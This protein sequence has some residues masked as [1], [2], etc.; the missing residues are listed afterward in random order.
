MGKTGRLIKEKEWP[1]QADWYSILFSVTGMGFILERAGECAPALTQDPRT[2]NVKE[3]YVISPTGTVRYFPGNTVQLDE[4]PGNEPRLDLL[5]LKENVD[6]PGKMELV[7]RKGTPA[8]R[9]K[10]PQLPDPDSEIQIPIAVVGFQEY[11]DQIHGLFDARSVLDSEHHHGAGDALQLDD[12]AGEMSVKTDGTTVVMQNGQLHLDNTQIVTGD[13]DIEWGNGLELS[14][15]GIRVKQ[16]YGLRFDHV[17]SVAVEDQELWLDAAAVSG[18]GLTE[19]SSGKIKVDTGD[20]VAAGSS[21][22]SMDVGNGLALVS[23]QLEADLVSGGGLKLDADGKLYVDANDFVNGVGLTVSSG[24][25][26]LTPGTGLRIDTD[27]R[28]DETNGLRVWSEQLEVYAGTGVEFNADGK[29]RLNYADLLSALAGNGILVNNSVLEVGAS[30]GLTMDHGQLTGD[31]GAGITLGSYGL[32]LDPDETT[33]TLSNGAL[34]VL[35]SGIAGD[36]LTNE[37]PNYT[38]EMASSTGGSVDPPEGTHEYT[39]GAEVELNAYPDQD[40]DFSS[41]GGDI[42][43]YDNPETI[44]INSDLYVKG[45]FEPSGIKSSGENDLTAT[46]GGTD[47]LQVALGE[48]VG[49]DSGVLKVKEGTGVSIGSGNPV[50]INRSEI[51]GST[52][53]TYTDGDGVVRGETNF[54]QHAFEKVDYSNSAVIDA[55]D[56][57]NYVHAT[58]GTSFE[59]EDIWIFPC[60]ISGQYDSYR[61]ELEVIYEQGATDESWWSTIR[62]ENVGGQDGTEQGEI[63]IKYLALTPKWMGSG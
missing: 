44:T 43:S 34:K 35:P 37:K 14:N 17:E 54:F 12:K 19:D 7:V 31:V 10:A 41:W 30:D 57:S 50:S 59:G 18:D 21:G 5:V 62:L 11:S 51:F 13:L 38:L 29:L 3:G 9:P 47:E 48:T 40:Y 25:I 27:L 46:S 36:G 16:G 24:D 2:M 23:G 8:E 60:P 26:D 4:N 32:S 61:N 53:S 39:A 45:Y 15:G 42:E 56:S 28:T 6:D 20:G 52:I 33:L 55:A 63:W 58:V 1:F 22:V 49:Q